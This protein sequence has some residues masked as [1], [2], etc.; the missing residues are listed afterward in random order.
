MTHF[1]VEFREQFAGQAGVAALGDN[2]ARTNELQQSVNIFQN[3]AVIAEGDLLL[4]ETSLAL[5]S[6]ASPPFP[7]LGLKARKIKHTNQ[8]WGLLL[9]L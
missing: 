2:A 6:E 5:V 8:R 7:R 9:E 1:G 3:C 4:G